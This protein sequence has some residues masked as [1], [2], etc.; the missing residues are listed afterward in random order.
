[1]VK[2]NTVTFLYRSLTPPSSFHY[3][4]INWLVM[5][6]FKN[7][8]DL[9]IKSVVRISLVQLL[10][11]GDRFFWIFLWLLKACLLPWNDWVPWW[12]SPKNIPWDENWLVHKGCFL[13]F[14][15]SKNASSMRFFSLSSWSPSNVI[16]SK[17][18]FFKC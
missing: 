10:F 16:V 14:P 11:H 13:I 5:V 8:N 1:M 4:V 18:L 3:R 6:W 12:K 2:S 9:K 17:L 15:K 7:V